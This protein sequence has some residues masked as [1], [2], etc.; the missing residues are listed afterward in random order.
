MG[1]LVLMLGLTAYSQFVII[2]AMERDRIAAGGAINTADLTNP[3]TVDFNK[4]HHRSEQVEGITLLLGLATVI[5]V[6][7]AET[8][9]TRE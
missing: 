2:P 7:R 4:L 5:C 1:L 9:N 6:A 3:A 8:G